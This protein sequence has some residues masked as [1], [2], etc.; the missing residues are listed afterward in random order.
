MTRREFLAATT[1]VVG[2]GLAAGCA[3][4][5]PPPADTKSIL[6]VGAGMAGLSAARSLAD[7]GWPVRLIEARDRIGGRIYTNRDWGMPLEFGASWVHGTTDNPLMELAR[8]AQAQLVPTDYYGWAK[9]AVDPRLRPL[10]Y[11]KKS[12]RTFVH[13]ARYQVDGGSLGAAVNAAADSDELTDSDRAQLT[14]YL[15]TEIEDEYAASANQLS[16][17][18]FDEG[19]YTGGDQSVVTSGYDALPKLLAKGL[20]ISLNTPVTAI[21][22]RENSVVVRAGARSFEGPA[23]IVTVPLGVLKSRAIAFDPPLPDGHAHAVQA[24]GFGVLSKSFFRFER[25]TWKAENAFYLYLSAD[26]GVWS[27]WFTLPSAAGPIVLAFNAGD[28]GRSMEASSPGDLMTSALPI[29][30]QLLGDDISPV[31][32]RTSTWSADPYAGGSYS[33]HA[34]GSGLDDR[35]RLQEPVSDRLYLAGEAVGVKNPS[36][37]AGALVSG[38]YAA[39]QLMHRLSR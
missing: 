12:W 25:R 21:V 34:P 30:R 28:R 11:D 36:T 15:T 27:Q 16:A 39:G 4:H 23:A 26:G 2:G 20:D 31:E 22:R 3:S 5:H 37:V 6:I 7:A 17:N 38:R 14:F 13:R 9:L 32:V 24:L 35:R 29:A 33:F 19:D 1:S 8:Q 18:T 10:D